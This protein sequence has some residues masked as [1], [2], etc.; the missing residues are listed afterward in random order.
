MNTNRFPEGDPAHLSEDAISRYLVEG[1]DD[2][3]DEHLGSCAVCR[4]RLAAAEAPLTIFRRALV[5]WSEAQSKSDTAEVFHAE[6][7]RAGFWGSRPWLPVAGLAMA[8]LL[9]FGYSRV[10]VSFHHP[11]PEQQDASLNP[12]AAPVSDSALLDQVDSEVSEAVPDAM[13][14]LTDLVSWDDSGNEIRSEAVQKSGSGKH[15]Q[16]AA[17]RPAQEVKN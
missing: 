16:P 14:P 13:A 5:D 2:A 12:V 4:E 15:L 8:A 1:P 9:M 7:N 11:V 17:T 3:A 10:P 6:R